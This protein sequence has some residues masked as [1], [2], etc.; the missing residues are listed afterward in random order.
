LAHD[1]VIG[2]IGK[3]LPPQTFVVGDDGL[4]LCNAAVPG[5][6]LA[7]GKERLT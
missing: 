4:E 6:R 3:K 1:H 7:E 5:G 2:G